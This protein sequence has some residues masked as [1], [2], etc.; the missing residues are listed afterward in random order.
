MPIDVDNRNYEKKEYLEKTFK[1]YKLDDKIKFNFLIG[2]NLSYEETSLLLPNSFTFEKN[3]LDIVALT[4]LQKFG[5][6]NEKETLFFIKMCQ[7]SNSD[8]KEIFKNLM[9]I[10]TANNKKRKKA[11]HKLCKAKNYNLVVEKIIFCLISQDLKLTVKE[12]LLLVIETLMVKHISS[13][14]YWPEIIC[15]LVKFINEDNLINKSI[16][17]LLFYIENESE[18]IIN[19]I[20]QEIETDNSIL[21]DIL[22]KLIALLV[23]NNGYNT[24]LMR[25]INIEIELKVNNQLL[26]FLR[27]HYFMFTLMGGE[28][29]D[30]K[31][32]M[33]TFLHKLSKFKN[34]R[35]LKELANI[36]S[37]LHIQK[38]IDDADL[39][40][41]KFYTTVLNFYT[42]NNRDFSTLMIPSALQEKRFLIHLIRTCAILS[43]SNQNNS[44]K[45]F[46]IIKNWP[47]FDI[48]NIKIFYRIQNNLDYKSNIDYILSNLINM[49]D[50]KYKEYEHIV[51]Q[52]LINMLPNKTIEEHL[53]THMCDKESILKI[54]SQTQLLAPEN[55]IQFRE[56]VFILLKS[57]STSCLKNILHFCEIGK[58]NKEDFN[59]LF[60]LGKQKID[61]VEDKIK[62]YGYKILNATIHC[63]EDTDVKNL[64]KV[65]YEKLDKTNLPLLSKQLETLAKIYE[66][67]P[68]S[69]CSD[70]VLELAPLL[71]YKNEK[72]KE[73]IVFFLLTILNCTKVN[74]IKKIEF[75]RITYDVMDY[76]SFWYIKRKQIG[77]DLLIKLSD[78]IPPQEIVNIF[79]EFLECNDK[80]VKTGLISGISQLSNH[81]GIYNILPVLLVDYSYLEDKSKLIIVQILSKCKIDT[82]YISYLSYLIED[83]IINN[84]ANFRLAGINLCTQLLIKNEKHNLDVE[85]FTHFLNLIWF[86]IL[87]KN[88]EIKK[89]FEKFIQEFTKTIGG[90]FFIKYL[91]QGLYHPSKKVQKRYMEI[92]NIVKNNDDFIN[93]YLLVIDKELQ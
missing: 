67:A 51:S 9:H 1:R 46:K 60:E 89:V 7:T 34:K 90:Q 69:N 15:L 62:I 31:K 17:I 52:I 4:E 26:I 11:V 19:F 82:K 59:R 41:D 29:T 12:D 65:L 35:V 73:K 18:N 78:I 92:F 70:L 3:E 2:R 43:T 48:N 45:V 77:V 66:K 53:I 56:S 38:L 63:I 88:I 27:S 81:C 68:F 13:F 8:E 20:N 86:N 24:T 91:I 5:N 75:M 42:T 74:N 28:I 83:C 32:E 93:E 64:G 57:N 50:V 72:V 54:F 33:Y 76:L 36:I 79:L 37:H 21:Q 85:I 40:F 84:D 22:S 80:N 23:I 30:F 47:D 71:K 14:L 55:Y 16:D 44:V 87:E 39:W 61:G 10:F 6:F 49:L 58:F 25:F